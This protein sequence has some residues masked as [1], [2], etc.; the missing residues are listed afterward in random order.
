MSLTGP[1]VVGITAPS[2]AHQ[3]R[4]KSSQEENV[5]DPVKSLELLAKRLLAGS[6]TGRGLYDQMVSPAIESEIRS[7]TK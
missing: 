2:E 1:A 6:S 7:L 4:N 5:T 3:E